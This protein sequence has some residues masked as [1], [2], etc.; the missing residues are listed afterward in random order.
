MKKAKGLIITGSTIRLVIDIVLGIFVAFAYNEFVTKYQ[1]E[2]SM[3]YHPDARGEYVAII[4][5]TIF[6]TIFILTAII[7]YICV[8]MLE[9]R[10]SAI[11]T[12]ICGLISLPIGL[13][14]FFGGKAALK[15]DSRRAKE[16]YGA[17][18]ARKRILSNK[19]IT[20]V[21][22]GMLVIY[23]VLTAFMYITNVDGGL[24]GSGGPY[25]FERLKMDYVQTLFGKN[26]TGDATALEIASISLYV[27]I[28][29]LFGFLYAIFQGCCPSIGY[30]YKNVK[31]VIFGL[32]YLSAVVLYVVFLFRL[33][34][35]LNKMLT[36]GVTQETGVTKMAA[37][38][39][40]LFYAFA[41][42]L[43]M[44]AASYASGLVLTLISKIRPKPMKP[45][46]SIIGALVTFAVLLGGIPL[47]EVLTVLL[48]NLAIAMM[49][50]VFAIIGFLILFA[51]LCAVLGE[52][53]NRVVSIRLDDD[54]SIEVNQ[55]KNKGYSTATYINSNGKTPVNSNKHYLTD[56]EDKAID[57]YLKKH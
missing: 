28:P 52:L 57:E 33:P 20:G 4:G 22:I 55:Y 35:L 56:E 13:F 8:A 10:G 47:V 21:F 29:F 25:S 42:S 5:F 9:K 49:R 53:P 1:D 34:P 45:G 16:R 2:V 51:V 30:R 17:E 24:I 14:D 6:V 37:Y 26:F 38:L 54:S 44:N 32:T 23:F 27:L 31:L 40:P 36:R 15:E 41:F 39:M 43:L 19:A 11:I 18:G 46:F 3:Y 48:L 7:D 50:A 12:M